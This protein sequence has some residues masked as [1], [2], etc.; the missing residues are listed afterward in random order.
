MHPIPHARA[1]TLSGL[2]PVIQS[3]LMNLLLSLFLSTALSPGETAPP[4][5]KIETATTFGAEI[6]KGGRCY[7][8][9]FSKDSLDAPR[10]D[11]TK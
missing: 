4:A 10:L 1:R 7:V 6:T 2:V 9:T 11:I 5:R 8:P 3:P